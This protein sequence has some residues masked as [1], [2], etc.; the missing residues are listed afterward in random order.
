MRFLRILYNV[1]F[2]V[3]FFFYFVLFPRALTLHFFCFCS[4]FSLGKPQKCHKHNYARPALNLPCFFR[5]RTKFTTPTS[6]A[7]QARHTL[8]PPAR[9][10]LFLPTCA[11]LSAT[12]FYA[13]R[14]TFLRTY[15]ARVFCEFCFFYFKFRAD[16]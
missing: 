13:P 8:N 15:T 2:C 1:L 14:T 7:I 5:A 12:R 3:F 6:Q 10:A 9:H 16:F 11:I 4:C